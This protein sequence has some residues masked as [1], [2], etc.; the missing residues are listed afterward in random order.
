MMPLLARGI[1]EVNSAG[2]DHVVVDPMGPIYMGSICLFLILLPFILVLFL[3]Y[4]RNKYRHQQILA[5]ME[6]GLPITDL[7][8]RPQIRNREVNWVRSLSAGIGFL[9]VGLLLTAVWV[10]LYVTGEARDTAV[11]WL[12]IPIVIAGL[13]LIYLFRGI[14]Q[15][16]YEKQKQKENAAPPQ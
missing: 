11:V 12:V 10:W 1:V 16:N 7:I 5:A 3:A 14:L 8:A 6:K 2:G 9:F 13:G 4:Y 15:K